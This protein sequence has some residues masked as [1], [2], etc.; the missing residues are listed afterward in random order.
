MAQARKTGGQPRAVSKKGSERRVHPFAYEAPTSVEEAV[1]L[2]ARHAGRARPMAGGT[3]LIVQLRENR[4]TCDLVV[5]VKRIP[6]MTTIA[7]EPGRRVQIG[8]ATPLVD[9]ARHPEIARHFPAVAQACSLI[10]SISIQHR[11][12]LG[13]N[14]GNASPSADGVA[15]LM[16]HEAQVVVAGPQGRRV[17]PVEEV[18]TG[19]GQTCLAPD[20]LLVSFHLPWPEP[21]TSSHYLRFTPR[22]EMDIAVAGVAVALTL[23]RQGRC[24][25]ARIAL[26]AV[27]PTVVRAQEAEQVLAGQ[28][29]KPAS[30]EELEQLLQETARRAREASRPISDVRGSAAYRLHL[31]EVLTYRALL[32]CLN[33]LPDASPAPA[34]A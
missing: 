23:D 31:V 24:R 4:R 2:L 17:L 11:A 32:A 8:A 9:I 12:S 22:N 33:R 16:V 27:A 28:P 5:D 14:L 7:V 1:A 6:E 29:L 15:P 18:C 20:E 13:G 3:D 10:G 19:P 21:Q 26:S 25:R 30:P 34:P